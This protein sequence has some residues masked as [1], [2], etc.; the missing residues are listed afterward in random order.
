[1][2]TDGRKADMENCAMETDGRKADMRLRPHHLLC[3][4]GYEGNGYDEH[5]VRRMTAYVTQMRREEN[6]RIEITL[7]PDDICTACPNLSDAE[8]CVSDDKVLAFDRKVL[9]MFGLKEG[10]TYNYQKLIRDI[11]NHMTR[12]RLHSIC[13]TCSWYPVSLCRDRILGVRTQT[14]L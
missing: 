6:V 12:E 2:E 4:Q 9:E 5:F 10:E 14:D 8:H 11:D 3:T 13:G 1:M 7:R